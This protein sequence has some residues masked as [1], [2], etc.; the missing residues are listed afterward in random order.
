[1]AHREI[2]IQSTYPIA[3]VRASIASK[4]FDVLDN[5]RDPDLDY[6]VR[7]WYSESS[8]HSDVTRTAVKPIP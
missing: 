6:R 3:M 8:E 5:R 4:T 2:T 1:M 7:I